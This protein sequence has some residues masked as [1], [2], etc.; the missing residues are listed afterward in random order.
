MVFC[1]KRRW[2]YRRN[3]DRVSLEVLR[4]RRDEQPSATTHTTTYGIPAKDRELVPVLSGVFPGF[5]L[6]VGHIGV[7]LTQF[8]YK[9]GGP[10]RMYSPRLVVPLPASARR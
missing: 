8:P 9:S 10:G 1:L 4:A 5:V 3:A 6:G 7:T 2:E